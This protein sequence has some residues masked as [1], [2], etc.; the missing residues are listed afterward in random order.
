MKINTVTVLGANGTMGRNVSAI[1]ASFG[2]A[3][4]YMI[5]RSLEKAEAAVEM[6]A[7]SVKAESIKS[8]LIAKTY[9]DLE[10]CIKESDLVFESVSENVD[11]KKDIYNQII[12]FLKD[13]VIIS[14]GTSGISIKDLS[15]IFEEKAN[16]FF[17]I[18]FF[19]PPYNLTL[20]ELISHDDRQK[21]LSSEIRGYLKNS[22]R[23]TVVEVKDSPSFL[24]N[25][26]GFYVI[27]A[28]M[29]L[30]EE[31]KEEGGIDYIDAILG[32]YTGRN[33]APLTTADFV[34]LDVTKSI[35]DYIN[36]NTQDKF[37]NY[38]EVPSYLNTLVN[39]GKL[40]RKSGYGLYHK[41]RETNQMYVYDVATNDFRLKNK[42]SFDFSN[43]MISNIRIGDYAKA[44][45]ILIN[46][47]SKEA[48]ICKKMLLQYII[49]SLKIARE[50]SNDINACDDAMS[51]GFAWLPP[52]ATIELFGGVEIVKGLADKY[53]D[54]R[55]ISIINDEQLLSVL[56]SKSK[57]DYR[58]YL[59]ARY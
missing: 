24:G 57:Y 56:P 8:R 59:K 14:T 31:Y 11:I 3:K 51:S 32:S 28:A 17:G 46:D 23:R 40:G 30:A 36:E 38:F 55:Y 16:R 45:S 35:I 10:E 50:V 42:Y 19:N 53:L 21:E 48:I 4:V 58:I 22:L 29:Q 54:E 1:F 52:I 49:Y 37:N 47:E 44:I 6:A 34:G 13:D 43:E 5:C 41:D 25:R 2:Q 39:E 26:I 20:C 33:M 27:N 15:T 12:P 9:D 18:H 7:N